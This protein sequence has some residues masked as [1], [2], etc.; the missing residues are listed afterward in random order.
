MRVTNSIVNIATAILNAQ[1]KMGGATK[2]S[3]NPFF[4]SNYADY[5]AVLEVVKEPLNEEGVSIIQ[6]TYS[7]AAGHYVE[8]ILLHTSGEF[9]SSGPLRLELTK[10]DMQSLGSSI[11]YSR[12][13]QLQALLGI[14]SFDD[15]GESATVRTPKHESKP[16]A[17]KVVSQAADA[18][19]GASITPPVSVLPK[20]EVPKSRT[21]FRLPANPNATTL[22]I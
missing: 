11:T 6:S 10:V 2:G 7:D 21:T 16:A 14:P 17:S 18:G 1:K 3:K 15:D 20:E 9:I 12:R 5:G 13:Y 22:K 8:T 19:L 4:K